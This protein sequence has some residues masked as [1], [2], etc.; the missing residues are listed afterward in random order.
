MKSFTRS[1]LTS[2][3]STAVDFATLVGLVELV[4]LDYKLATFI[5][6]IVGFL[7]NFTINRQWA[8]EATHGHVGWQFA[9]VLPVQGGSTALQT[10]GVWLFHTLLGMRYWTAKIVVSVLVYLGWNYPMNRFWVFPHRRPMA[11]PEAPL[12]SPP[13]SGARPG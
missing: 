10:L 4:H 3:L 6:T 8:F 13:S 9:R 5:G 1:V 12:A 2:I 11:S 7:T